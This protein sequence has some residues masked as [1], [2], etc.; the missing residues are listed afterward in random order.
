MSATGFD[1][2]EGVIWQDGQM[3]NWPD[4]KVHVLNHGLH[5]ASSVFEGMRAYNGKIFK[6][7]EHHLR[8]HQ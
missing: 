4:A 5:Y 3:V 7:Q 6:L 1:Q 2:R 8:F